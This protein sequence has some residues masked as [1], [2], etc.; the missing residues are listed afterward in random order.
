MMEN[1]FSKEEIEEYERERLE[2]LREQFGITEAEIILIGESDADLPPW[3][4]SWEVQSLQS[5][6]AKE[7]SPQRWLVQ[8]LFA[9]EG[10]ALLAAESGT[11]KTWLGLHLATAVGEGKDWLKYPTLQ[12]KVLY[13]NGE[14]PEFEIQRR[15]LR[16]GLSEDYPGHVDFL[17]NTMALDTNE[18]YYRLLEL[19]QQEKY[20]LIIGDTLSKLHSG[21]AEENDNDAMTDLMIKCRQVAYVSG[22]LFLLLH[23]VSKPPGYPLSLLH[24]IRGASA[25]RDN[26][27][28]AILLQKQDKGKSAHVQMTNAKNWFGAEADPIKTWLIDEGVLSRFK[29]E[30]VATEE[31]SKEEDDQDIY[32]WIDKLFRQLGD[33]LSVSALRA[34]VTAAQKIV[35]GDI[36]KKFEVE[37]FIQTYYVGHSKMITRGPRWEEMH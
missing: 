3:E 14:V 8:G 1:E 15:L 26:A 27:G 6:V 7:F 12:G 33:P 21:R 10:V 29:W 35:L 18:D 22:G 23:H 20:D 11:Y 28:S 37:G 31:E 17:H 30:D 2:I 13:I 34:S 32:D 25:I 16:L 9:T 5:L 4:K 19:V 36:L 24:R